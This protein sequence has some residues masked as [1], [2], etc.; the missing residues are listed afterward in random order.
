M[1]NQDGFQNKAASL[2]IAGD[3]SAGH[4]LINDQGMFAY[5][6]TGN[7]FWELLFSVTPPQQVI[8]AT[9]QLQLA[10]VTGLT[11]S[12]QL[13]FH[14]IS[15]TAVALNMRNAGGNIPYGQAGRVTAGTPGG[16][17]NITGSVVFT[18]AFPTGTVPRVTFGERAFTDNTTVVVNTTGVPSA[19]GFNWRAALASGL[20]IPVGSIS[21]DWHAYT[22]DD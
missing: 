13:R 14:D 21:F 6:S 10:D 17:G 8:Q 11:T 12:G 15:D 4:I 5:D 20:A 1:S 9:G 16:V 22:P 3:P 7:L 19:T 18:N 2:V